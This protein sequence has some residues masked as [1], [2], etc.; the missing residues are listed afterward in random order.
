MVRKL[1]LL[2]FIPVSL[3]AQ[4]ESG[5]YVH[6][7]LFCFRGSIAYGKMLKLDANNSYLEG[8]T[9]YFADD[10]ISLRGDVYFFTGHFNSDAPFKMYHSLLTGA[11]YHFKTNN[12]FDPYFGLE[13]GMNLGQASN[14]TFGQPTPTFAPVTTP[15]KTFTPLFSPIIGFNFFGNKW[16][17]LA[18]SARYV[19]GNFADNYN[20]VSLGEFRFSFGLGFNLN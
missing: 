1:L 12:H 20:A 18:L 2:L 11:M 14:P 13:V 4:E 5:R 10:N 9:E 7:G 17:H 15:E 8:N 19:T 3:F 6:R 16:F